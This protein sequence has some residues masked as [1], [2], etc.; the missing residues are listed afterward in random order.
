MGP[1]LAGRE[2]GRSG[3]KVILG[4]RKIIAHDSSLGDL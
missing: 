4:F 2:L 1:H 3:N